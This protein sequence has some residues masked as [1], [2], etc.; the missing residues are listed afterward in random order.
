MA[1]SNSVS[2]AEAVSRL[3]SIVDQLE[4]GDVPLEK[5]FELFEEGVRLARLCST[6]LS[7]AEKKIEK[8]SRNEHGELTTSPAENLDDK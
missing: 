8:L 1:E 2:F 7:E 5:S 6:K 4:R 3:E